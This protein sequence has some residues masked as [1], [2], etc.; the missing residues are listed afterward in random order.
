[1]PDRRGAK[2]ARNHGRKGSGKRVIHAPG[3]DTLDGILE[4]LR[5]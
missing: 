3:L 5:R 4:K 2:V 1:V